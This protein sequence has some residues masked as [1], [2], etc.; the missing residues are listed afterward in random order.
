M[1][2]DLDPPQVPTEVKGFCNNCKTPLSLP[3]PPIVVNESVVVSAILIPHSQGVHC[4]NCSTYHNIAVQPTRLD[5]F[6][7]AM[8]KPNLNEDKKIVPFTGHL[9][10]ISH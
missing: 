10:L 9:K 5:L 8:D 1:S 4:S 7:V 6:L 3:F 2:K